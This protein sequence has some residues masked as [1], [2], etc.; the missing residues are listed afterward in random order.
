MVFPRTPSDAHKNWLMKLKFEK[1]NIVSN[2]HEYV[3]T[4]T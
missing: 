2:L 4:K 1:V 3:E